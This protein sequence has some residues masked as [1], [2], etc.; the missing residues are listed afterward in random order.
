MHEHCWLVCMEGGG[1]SG[2]DI[3]GVQVGERL[4]A[5]RTANNIVLGW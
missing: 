3:R 5:S 2:T 4:D 1:T